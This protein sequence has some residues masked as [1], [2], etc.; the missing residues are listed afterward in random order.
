MPSHT[1]E[2]DDLEQLV[3]LPGWTR[4]FNHV[5]PTPDGFADAVYQHAEYDKDDE[6]Y[7]VIESKKVEKIQD[8][9]TVVQ[10]VVS[11]LKTGNKTE[12]EF[13]NVK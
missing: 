4:F 11:N 8:F 5:R 13:S 3:A 6:L 7:R 9:Y 10:S 1:D 2:L 12:M